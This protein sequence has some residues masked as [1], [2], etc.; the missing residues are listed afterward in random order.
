MLRRIRKKRGVRDSNCLLCYNKFSY[1]PTINWD[2]PESIKKKI[3]KEEDKAVQKYGHKGSL[4]VWNKYKKEIGGYKVILHRTNRKTHSLC[5]D[6][7]ILFLSQKFQ[8]IDDKIFKQQKVD[9]FIDCYKLECDKVDKK[10]K[11]IACFVKIDLDRIYLLAPI[12]PIAIFKKNMEFNF[13]ERYANF[14]NYAEYVK[15]PYLIKIITNRFSKLIDHSE[16]Y[17]RCI[18][19]NCL[20]IMRQTTVDY[21]WKCGFENCQTEWCSQCTAQ[22]ENKTCIEFK[23]LIS[24]DLKTYT[25]LKYNIEQGINK[26]CP[27]CKQIIEKQ[28][29]CNHMICKLCNTHF[30]WICLWIAPRVTDFDINPVYEHI[31]Q[32]HNV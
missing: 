5:L 30:C 20:G 17:K 27:N 9:K 15:L 31:K 16:I 32:N 11:D 6:C 12:I 23:L 10:N 1:F 14:Y 18:K 13:I 7:F 25:S 26:C 24:T 22:H 4:L 28:S 2:Q 3:R 19:W 29:G 21:I 8:E